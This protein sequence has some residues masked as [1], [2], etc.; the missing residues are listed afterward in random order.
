MN[1][2]VIEATDEITHV[3]LDG[4]LDIAGAQKVDPLLTALAESSKAL[5]VDL[6]QVSFLAS[7]GVRSLMLS[8][9]T[10]LRRSADMAVCGANENVEKVLRATGFD[11][12]VDIYPDFAS[13]AEAL[14]NKAAAF[15]SR[16]A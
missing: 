5:V 8:A 15:A 3:V 1:I 13:A 7:L 4:R 9:K 14:K 6:T 10:L 11:E 2:N 12:I 16:N